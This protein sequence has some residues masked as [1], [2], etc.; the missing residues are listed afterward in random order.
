MPSCCLV[1]R[2]KNDVRDYTHC[3]LLGSYAVAITPRRAIIC[4]GRTVPPKRTRQRA[5]IGP[6]KIAKV[7][8]SDR[9]SSRHFMFTELGNP[10]IRNVG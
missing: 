3:F 8:N 9:Q 5:T 6:A 4:T 2:R 1:P 10:R 7:L